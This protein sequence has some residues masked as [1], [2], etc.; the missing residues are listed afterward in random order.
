MSDQPALRPC[1][2]CGGEVMRR[3]ALW[4][5]EGDRDAVIHAEPSDCPLQVFQDDT[6]GGSLY[7]RW[8]ADLDAFA[9]RVFTREVERRRE[10]ARNLAMML[11]RFIWQADK[12]TGDTSF[13]VLAGKARELVERYGLTGEILRAEADAAPVDRQ[14]GSPHD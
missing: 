8:N 9:A 5:S 10:E 6:W 11:R 14:G 7:G 12:S 3:D 2:F 13:K 4:P 1:P